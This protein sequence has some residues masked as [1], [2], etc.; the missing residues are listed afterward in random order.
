MSDPTRL[1]LVRHAEPS[2]ETRNRVYGRLDVT[3]SPEGEEHAERLARLLATTPITAVY[4]SPLRRALAT[5]GPLAATHGL[6]VTVASDLREIDFG[7]L[8]G[9]LLSEVEA[10]FPVEA[11]W[12][13]APSSA[14]FPNGE[15]VA[16]LCARSTATVRGIVER[17]PG[18]TVA[19]VT[20]AVVIRAILA[21]ALGMSADALFRLDQGYGAISV[22][23]WFGERALVR[24]VNA[25]NL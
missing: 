4:A 24:L 14:A 25:P 6:T 17:H 19:V 10:R 8:E 21:E 18:E 13:D 16:A 11:R 15:S 7:D 20:H 3:L 5:A 1:L 12:T 22:I 23:D 2:A 9:V